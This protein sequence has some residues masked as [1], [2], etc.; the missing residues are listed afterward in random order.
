MK[1]NGTGVWANEETY[2][3]KMNVKLG[4]LSWMELRNYK[5]HTDK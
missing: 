3:E 4:T 1:K 5:K 2:N